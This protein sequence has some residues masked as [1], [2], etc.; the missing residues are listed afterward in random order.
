MLLLL[1]HGPIVLLDNLESAHRHFIQLLTA[2]LVGQCI[3][4]DASP[5]ARLA[6]SPQVYLVMHHGV[7]ICIDRYGLV[8]L[9]D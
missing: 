4:S 6:P 5:L 8:L 9:R 2:E 3:Q 1:P 7:E